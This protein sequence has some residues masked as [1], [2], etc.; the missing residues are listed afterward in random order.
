MSLS[1]IQPPEKFSFKQEDWQRWI[2]HFEHFRTASELYK[3]S[4]ENQVNILIYMMGVEGD[5]ANF[6]TVD[7]Q[8]HH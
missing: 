2:R 5:D 7:S 8:S 4:E 3:A 6:E 1:Q